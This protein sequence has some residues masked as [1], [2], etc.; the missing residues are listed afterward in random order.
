MKRFQV[1]PAGGGGY[2]FRDKIKPFL[3][4]LLEG[5]PMVEV[6]VEGIRKGVGGEARKAYERRV[7]ASGS[8]E[9]I[10]A[11]L[12]AGLETHAQ[13]LMVISFQ[14]RYRLTLADYGRKVESSES[15]MHGYNLVRDGEKYVKATM[16]Q[17]TRLLKSGKVTSERAQTDLASMIFADG[18]EEQAR[19]LLAGDRVTCGFARHILTFKC[20]EHRGY[21]A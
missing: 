12:L 14:Q 4:G 3:A 6:A 1:D 8:T 21:E 18:T 7:A 16:D 20:G 19:E 2:T 5:S 15:G 11:A 13:E 10:H 9:Q 17:A